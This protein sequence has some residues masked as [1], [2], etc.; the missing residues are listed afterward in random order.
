MD[1]NALLALEGRR[2]AEESAHRGLTLRLFGGIGFYLNASDPSLFH[3]LGRDPFHDLDF[4]GLSEERTEYKQLF[5]ELGYEIDQDMLLAA[6]GRRFLFRRSGEAVVEVDL[7]IDRLDMCHSL[8]LRKRLALRPETVP[9][10]DLALQKLQIVD[11][12]HK[13]T[14][15]VVV[16]L[17]DHDLGE[18]RIDV[19]DAAHAASLLSD[20]WGFYHTA[21]SNLGRIQE[22]VAS[23]P[24]EA[25][26]RELVSDRLAR[27]AGELERADKTRKWKM[28]AKVGTRKKWYNDVEEDIEAF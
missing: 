1:S 24:L 26:R 10:V 17:A 13:D 14:I 11:L 27:F 6:E 18:G 19:V 3:E 9:L 16:L 20:D 25:D 12:T 7:F 23:A 28:R 5:Q 15:D 21:T 8:E 22:F 2:I 4:V